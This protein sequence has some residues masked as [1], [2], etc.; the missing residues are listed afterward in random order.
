MSSS[1]PSPAQPF[2]TVTQDKFLGG[3]IEILQPAKGRHR[4]GLDAVY[5][6]AVLPEDTKGHVVDLGTGVGT[7][8]FCVASRLPKVACTGV[9][10]DEVVLDLAKKSLV[11]AQNSNFKDRISLIHANITAKGN[12]RHSSGLLSNMCD[13]VIMNPPYYA[14]GRFSVT[15]N[16]PRA[17]AHAL[18][19]RGVE[20]WVKTAKDIVRDGG[21]L[22]IVFRADGLNELLKVMGNR[23]GA[24]DI[25]PLRPAPDLPATRILVTA[26]AASKAPLRLLPGFDIH[27]TKGGAF[28]QHAEGVLR[29]GKGLEIPKR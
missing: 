9:E 18:D 11:L 1:A 21:T 14:D 25:I 12:K 3:K 5:L 23:F 28:T 26:V 4:A 24:I 16:A 17:S 22:S 7:A 8:A 10:L 27:E 6:A 13:H 19:E 20:P 2:Q 15:P 29:Y